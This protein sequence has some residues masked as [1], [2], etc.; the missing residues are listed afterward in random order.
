MR[1]TGVATLFLGVVLGV[2][3]LTGS[4]QAATNNCDPFNKG[5][6]IRAQRT[7]WG[8]DVL[9]AIKKHGRQ[10]RLLNADTCELLD[11]KKATKKTSVHRLIV[12]NLWQEEGGENG[13]P[14][15]VF[16][17]RVNKKKI[18]LRFYTINR[19]MEIEKIA[20]KTLSV[21]KGRVDL[22]ASDEEL[23]VNST[24]WRLL[25]WNGSI[26]LKKS[27]NSVRFFAIGD[28]G[29]VGE[30]KDAVAAAMSGVAEQENGIQFVATLGDNFYYDDAIAST[31]DE[32]WEENFFTPYGLDYL[33]APWYIG[34][35]NH[36]Y[37]DNNLDALLA[38]QDPTGQWSLPSNYYSVTYPSGSSS[39]LL[40]FVMLD[41]E[42]IDD[43]DE[44]YEEQLAWLQTT[45]E[46]STA[47]WL[48]VAGHHPVY[49]YGDHGDTSSMIEN[50]LPILKDNEVDLVLSGHDHDKQVIDH[51]DD[52]ILYVVSGAG[53]RLRD[54][55]QGENSL[56]AESSYG[57]AGIQIVKDS[58]VLKFYST[59]QSV[60]YTKT[61]TK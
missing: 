51:P 42:M 17:E 26:D 20:T 59:D 60:D 12:N 46:E 21:K 58:L 55:S 24:D 57:F 45:L 15:I 61:L 36:D 34:L 52:D 44:G 35:G 9:I 19:E 41:T 47:R 23:A 40:E 3:A 5:E 53:S 28:Q 14:E 22:A 32:D 39:P 11:K 49:S 27:E 30:N 13:S 56:F 6:V 29:E 33:T 18:S 50:V 48:V 31:T 2:F 16:T 10:I 4:A 43:E 7:A 25:R 8:Q 38:Y 37:D 1:I 54:T